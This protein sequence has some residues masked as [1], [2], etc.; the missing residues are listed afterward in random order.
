[1][2]WEITGPMQILLPQAIANRTAEWVREV[3][4]SKTRSA[5]RAEG[6]AREFEA[7]VL[8]VV[9]E[10]LLPQSSQVLFGSGSAGSVWRSM[11][12]EAV[13]RQIAERGDLGIARMVERAKL[14][15]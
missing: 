7:F 1:V 9:M 2:D 13:S 3:S 4:P 8:Q 6:A 14:E 10:Q 5:P 12:A 11:L 15:T